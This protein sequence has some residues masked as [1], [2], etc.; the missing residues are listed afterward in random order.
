MTRRHAKFFRCVVSWKGNGDTADVVVGR[1]GRCVRLIISLKGAVARQPLK[2]YPPLRELKLKFGH[3]G[4]AAQL[5]VTG[6]DAAHQ[7]GLSPDFPA[8]AAR[9]RARMRSSFGPEHC[10]SAIITFCH[11]TDAI[12]ELSACAEA[13]ASV[14]WPWMPPVAIRAEVW[15]D[16]ALETCTA[17]ISQT[18][19]H[20]Q[21]IILQRTTT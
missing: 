11:I 20:R 7:G 16:V 14:L 18:V 12:P 13:G 2:Y 8:A 5:R 9:T 17:F 4:N 6:A 10:K 3:D 19:L 1:S 21:A 15:L